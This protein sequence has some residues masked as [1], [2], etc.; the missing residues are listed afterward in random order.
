VAEREAETVGALVGVM[1]EPEEAAAQADWPEEAA[2]SV[3]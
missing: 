2:G 1:E 3:T